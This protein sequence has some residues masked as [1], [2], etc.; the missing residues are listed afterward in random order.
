MAAPAVCAQAAYDAAEVAGLPL[1]I[2]FQLPL[3]Y[4]LAISGH[5]DAN[6]PRHVPPE[7]P[8]MVRPE[9]MGWLQAWLQYPRLKRTHAAD[10]T[11]AFLSPRGPVRERLGLP[12]LAA[13]SGAFQ[14]PAAV[15][16]SIT[17]VSG[18]MELVRGGGLGDRMQPSPTLASWHVGLRA[19]TA[20]GTEVMRGLLNWWN[21]CVHGAA[22][23]RPRSTACPF[24]TPHATPCRR[25][26]GR[27]RQAGTCQ[28][29][30][31]WSAQAR[32]PALTRSRMPRWWPSCRRRLVRS[33]G[34]AWLFIWG[35]GGC[36]PGGCFCPGFLICQASSTPG[37]SGWLKLPSLPL[38]RCHTCRCR[39]GGG[40][41][42]PGLRSHPQPGDG[43]GDG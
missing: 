24:C 31:A 19:A 36:H 28:G 43:G 23:V 42:G 7:M 32:P 3:S 38:P 20:S 6:M 11:E 33:L 35:D 39:G 9:A 17:I 26:R 1:G 13:G 21:E 29:P 16:R 34:C 5:S 12:P 37:P 15:P 2:L 18:V 41:C 4:A 14:V 22:Y 8:G 27:C 25:Q 30:T 10:L 40:V